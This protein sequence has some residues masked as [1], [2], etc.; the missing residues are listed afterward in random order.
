MRG[1]RK[2][3]VFSDGFVETPYWWE[4]AAPEEGR[5]HAELRDVDFL[6]VGAGLTGL[7]AAI[8]LAGAGCDVA[9]VDAQLIGEAASTR[10]GGQIRAESKVATSELTRRFGDEVARGVLADFTAGRAFLG[11]RI[12]ALG[13]D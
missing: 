10:N 7:N 6:V 4:A 3:T 2:M 9:V 1:W 8:T 5:P 12:A 13:I 11:E